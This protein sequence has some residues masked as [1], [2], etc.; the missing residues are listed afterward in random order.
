MKEIIRKYIMRTLH[1]FS[2][3]EEKI[4]EMNAV[5][6]FNSNQKYF[7]FQKT[8]FNELNEYAEKRNIKIDKVVLIS[9]FDAEA[10]P[11]LQTTKSYRVVA[12]SDSR[13]VISREN[14]KIV[15]KV[16]LGEFLEIMDKEVF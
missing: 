4:E 10:M 13:F 16:F 8:L 14:G 12:K 5:V 1:F 3:H 2:N 6:L 9:I 15:A 11:D 7:E